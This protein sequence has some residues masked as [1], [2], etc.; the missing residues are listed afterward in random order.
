MTD[1]V[2]SKIGTVSIVHDYAN[3][4]IKL[5]NNPDV[6]K[7]CVGFYAE[8]GNLIGFSELST[9]GTSVPDGT[10]SIKLCNLT[11]FYSPLSTSVLL[12]AK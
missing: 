12:Y 3:D 2:E 11:D 10:D 5:I 8:S 7:I 9:V 4:T 6:N 1:S